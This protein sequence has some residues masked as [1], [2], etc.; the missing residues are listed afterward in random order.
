[1]Y[2]PVSRTGI[3]PSVSSLRAVDEHIG[4]SFSFPKFQGPA[5]KKPNQRIFLLS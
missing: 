4:G 1:M 2:L 5:L 3:V